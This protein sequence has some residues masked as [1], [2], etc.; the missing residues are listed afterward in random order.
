[1]LS[2]TIIGHKCKLVEIEE[3]YF[4]HV[5]NWRNDSDINKYLNQPYKLTLDLQK[6]WYESYLNDNTQILYI[7]LDEFDIPV[8]TTGFTH[9]DYEN[10]CAI[11]G[12]LIIDKKYR[13]TEIVLNYYIALA[14]EAFKYF[15]YIYGHVVVNNDRANRLNL[16]SGY[17]LSTS[18]K[19]PELCKN[20]RFVIEEY[21]STKVDFYNSYNYKLY[22]KLK[23]L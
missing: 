15:D 18:I 20:D 10:R 17:K 13:G 4:E 3:K 14:E 12:R 21:V 22:K 16:K 2:K 23:R 9:I 5:I 7:I 1:M 8:G 19:Y 6:K 11:S